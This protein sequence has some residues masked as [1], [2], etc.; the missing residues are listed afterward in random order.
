MFVVHFGVIVLDIALDCM[1]RLKLVLLDPHLRD[2][3]ALFE[4]VELLQGRVGMR[5]T[6]R[7]FASLRVNRFARCALPQSGRLSWTHIDFFHRLVH[8]RRAQRYFCDMRLHKVGALILTKL[9]DILL[10]SVLL[11]LV[12][13]FLLLDKI[14]GCRRRLYISHRLF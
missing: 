3:L 13:L 11:P 6:R 8:K 2:L 5:G 12:E 14:I 10:D 4:T 7:P 9:I 1:E